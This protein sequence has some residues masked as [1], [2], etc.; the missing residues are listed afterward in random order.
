MGFPLPFF[1]PL[2][3]KNCSTNL[4]ISIYKLFDSLSLVD[5]CISYLERMVSDKEG[6]VSWKNKNQAPPSKLPLLI[7][8]RLPLI[9]DTVNPRAYTYPPP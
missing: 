2:K 6:G 5:V 9:C 8:Q 3:S 7:G 1:L 4:I